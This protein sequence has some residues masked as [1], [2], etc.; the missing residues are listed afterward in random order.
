MTLSLSEF[1]NSLRELDRLVTI[2]TFNPDD[3]NWLKAVF[4]CAK[5]AGTHALWML[6]RRQCPVTGDHYFLDSAE[7]EFSLILKLE[8]VIG[9]ANDPGGTEGDKKQMPYLLRKPE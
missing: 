1:H 6:G 7:K 4:V 2:S 3:P 5:N 8:D 9:P